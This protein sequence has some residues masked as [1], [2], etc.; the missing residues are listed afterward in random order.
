MKKFVFTLE[1]VYGVKVREESAQ[2]EKLLNLR[3]RK[4]R[5]EGD[6]AAN[7]AKYDEQKAEYQIK[8]AGGMSGTIMRNYG[9]YFDYLLN[10]RERLEKA[11]KTMDTHIEAAQKVL[12]ALMNEIKVLDRMKEEQLEEY[13]REVKIEEDKSL[14]DYMSG[15]I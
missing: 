11:I 7:V 8:S 4:E 12:L 14:E 3:K 2:R 10:D 1:K 15:R 9:D 5:L 6:L 13:K